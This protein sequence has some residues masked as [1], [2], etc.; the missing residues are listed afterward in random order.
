MRHTRQPHSRPQFNQQINNNNIQPSY[1]S[2]NNQPFQPVQEVIATTQP[3]YEADN[4]VDDEDGEIDLHNKEFCVDVSS[5]QPVVWEER[6][7]E[8]CTTQWRMECQSRAE[9]VCEDVSET[10]CDVSE[11]DDGEDD[12]DD[13]NEYVSG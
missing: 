11:D 6:E 5:Y 3:P 2:G 7:G 9:E 13:D 10:T 8:V 12:S 4:E 1:N